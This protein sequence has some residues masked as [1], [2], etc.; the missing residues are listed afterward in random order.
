MK[1]FK[2]ILL[3]F[4]PFSFFACADNTRADKVPDQ[5]KKILLNTI[6]QFNNAF[7]RGDTAALESMISENYVHTNGASAPIG[8]K[9][10]VRYLR[11]RESEITSGTL[12]IIAYTMDEIEIKFYDPVAIVTGKI[13][14]Q[15]K[16]EGTIQTNTYRVTH[17]WVYK[18]GTWK[19]AGFHDGKIL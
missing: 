10:W 18:G 17:V 14:V 13:R 15:S 7:E 12:N 2:I 3:L 9:E 11:K 4:I 6:D 8:K 16:K 5:A 1:I 19:R